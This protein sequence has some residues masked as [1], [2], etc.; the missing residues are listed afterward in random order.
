MPSLE[1]EPDPKVFVV[2]NRLSIIV[3]DL[4]IVYLYMSGVTKSTGLAEIDIWL[5]LSGFELAWRGKD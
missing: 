5:I 1:F 3:N 2:S 4:K